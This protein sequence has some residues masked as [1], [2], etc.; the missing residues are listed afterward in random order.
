M[1]VVSTCSCR[2]TLSSFER[3]LLSLLSIELEHAGETRASAPMAKR[4]R[5]PTSASA[6][7]LDSDASSLSGAYGVSCRARAERVALRA[8]AHPDAV[9]DSPQGLPQLRGGVGPPFSLLGRFRDKPRGKFSGL[10]SLAPPSSRFAERAAALYQIPRRADPSL[11]PLA[12]TV[13]CA[14]P[15]LECAAMDLGLAGKT[16]VVT[17]ASR[18][19]GRET[20]RQLCAEGAQVLLVARSEDELRA[21]TDECEGTGGRASAL[22]LDVTDPDAGERMLET[23]TERSARS[24]CSSTTRARRSGATSTTFPTR[25]GRQP[26]S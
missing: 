21:A 13:Q 20:A 25:T 14:L 12:I 4:P 18:G 24:T 10:C 2:R 19:I 26:G 22:V 16:C 7:N 5:Q 11:F 23:A 9:R 3:A 1:S 17:G 6:V 15:L 8:G